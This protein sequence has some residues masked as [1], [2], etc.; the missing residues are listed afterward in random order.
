[1]IDE[2]VRQEKTTNV[3]ERVAGV[4]TTIGEERVRR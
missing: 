1:M 2:R 4:K 3:V